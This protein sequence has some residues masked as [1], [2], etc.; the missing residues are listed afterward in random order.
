MRKT[1]YILTLFFLFQIANAQTHEI[2]VFAGGSNFIGDVGRTDYIN[3][4]HVAFGLLYKWNVNP[5]YSWRLSAMQSK[6][7]G[8]DFAAANTAR[9][10]RG[11]NFENTITEFSAG[12][13]FNFFDFNLHKFGFV[14]TPY[15]YSG[16]SYYLSDNLYTI[17]KKYYSSGVSGGVALPIIAGFK[18][19]ISDNFILGLEAGAR[20]TFSDDLDGSIPKKKEFKQYAFG[21][22]NSKDWYVFTGLTLT[23]TFGNKPCYCND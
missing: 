2:G 4:R 6:V 19:K 18:A 5:R 3:P 21:N 10:N 13:E 15:L 9:K 22:T 23:Y 8:N 17:N 14:S 7:G 12:F 1:T 20:Y 11:L 16:V